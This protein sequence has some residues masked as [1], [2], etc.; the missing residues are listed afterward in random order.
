MCGNVWIGVC[1]NV[2]VVCENVWIVHV[3][4]VWKLGIVCESGWMVCESVWIGRA[5]GG[6]NMMWIGHEQG[7]KMREQCEHLW[8]CVNCVNYNGTGG[9]E[10]GNNPTH[11]L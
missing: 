3:N 2:W 7:R 9:A 8:K 6:E 1:E 5:E 11:K 10:E 4:R